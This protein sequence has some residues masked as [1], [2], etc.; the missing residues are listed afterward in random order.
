MLMLQRAGEQDREARL[1]PTFLELVSKLGPRPD[2]LSRKDLLI[3]KADEDQLVPWSASQEFVSL[4][5]PDKAEVIGYPGV[6][7]VF[8]GGMREQ[9]AEWIVQWRLRH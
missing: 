3:L 1:P 5:P 6:G 7:H 4:L 2:V 8:T 9:S